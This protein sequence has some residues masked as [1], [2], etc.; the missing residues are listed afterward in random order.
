MNGNRKYLNTELTGGKQRLGKMNISRGIF[1]GDSLSLLLFILAMVVINL[2]LSEVKRSYD[3]GKGMVSMEF[4]IWKYSK[5]K[6]KRGR[7]KESKGNEK[8]TT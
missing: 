3:L 7:F 8:N 1:L 5:L 2:I 6:M 4:M